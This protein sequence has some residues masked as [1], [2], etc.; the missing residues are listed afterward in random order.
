[1]IKFDQLP[2]IR[3]S[4]ARVAAPVMKEEWRQHITFICQL[5]SV[6]EIVYVGRGCCMFEKG[7]EKKKKK[8]KGASGGFEAGTS[9][10]LVGGFTTLPCRLS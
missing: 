7:K 3:R 6:S 9:R 4:V 1:M 8:K 2:G 10:L 5:I